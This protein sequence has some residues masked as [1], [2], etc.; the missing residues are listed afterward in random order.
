MAE[1]LRKLG[2]LRGDVAY[3]PAARRT[4][5]RRARLHLVSEALRPAETTDHWQQAFWRATT[6]APQARENFADALDRHQPG[7]ST[8]AP[9]TRRRPS[10]SSSRRAS[11]SP[12]RRRRSSRRTGC[13]RGA[14]RRGSKAYGLAIDDS[15]GHTGAAHRAGRLSR[16]CSGRIGERISRRPNSWRCSSTLDAPARRSR[17]RSGAPPARSNGASSAISIS[18]RGAILEKRAILLMG[19][20]GSRTEF[21]IPAPTQRSP[22]Q[23]AWRR[24]R[25]SVILKRLSRRS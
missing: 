8:D 13:W 25:S 11:R 2:A 10:R 15:A 14:W 20:P 17:G 3:V 18:G 7:G 21:R 9:M 12:A 23:S 22:G 5:R 16:P 1:L 4:M 19:F 6:S 24:K